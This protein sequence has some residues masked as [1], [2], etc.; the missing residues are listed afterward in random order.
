MD[1]FWKLTILSAGFT[2]RSVSVKDVSY[3][4]VRVPARIGN[5][6]TNNNVGL[7]LYSNNP[8]FVSSSRNEIFDKCFIKEPQT[9][10]TSVGLYNS[11]RELM[12]IAKLSKPIAKTF[13]TDLLIK[14]RLSW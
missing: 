12:A 14:I 13:D 7:A 8:T 3:Y 5:S 11:S 6:P 1:I 9:Y 10:I 2:A 4:Y